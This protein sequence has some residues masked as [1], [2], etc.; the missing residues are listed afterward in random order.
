MGNW[1]IVDLRLE[2][3]ELWKFRETMPGGIR[4]SGKM[5]SREQVKGHFLNCEDWPYGPS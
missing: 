4:G 1:L 5:L 3:L 2:N